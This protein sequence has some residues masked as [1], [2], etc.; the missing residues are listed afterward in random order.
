[1]KFYLYTSESH[2]YENPMCSIPVS[3]TQK[4]FDYQ[5]DFSKKPLYGTI[6]DDASFAY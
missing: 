5:V 3:C 4:P 2:T 1:M 6:K